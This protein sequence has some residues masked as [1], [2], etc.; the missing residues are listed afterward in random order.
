MP[1]K[2]RIRLTPSAR[3]QLQT[4]L[5]K[6][7]SDALRQARARILL[8]ADETGHAGGPWDADIA[9]AVEV[10]VATVERV[11]RRFVEDGLAAA[12]ERKTPARTYVRRLDG[13]A[14][15]KLIA[16]ACGAL[17][18]NRHGSAAF[19]PLRRQQCKAS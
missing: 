17:S 15:A 12:L 5:R 14:A 18:M 13:S 16:L 11:Q 2:Y 6:Q 1:I 3:A 7:R 9:T 10:S 8:K 4:L 19:T